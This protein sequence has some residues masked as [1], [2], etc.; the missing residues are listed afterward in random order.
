MAKQHLR[1]HFHHKGLKVR[2]INVRRPNEI[3]PGD[4]EIAFGG[5]G[6]IISPSGG[7]Q[8]RHDRCHDELIHRRV[9]TKADNFILRIAYSIGIAATDKLL[10]ERNTGFGI[11]MGEVVRL[12]E[13]PVVVVIDGRPFSDRRI[14]VIHDSGIR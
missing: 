2:T 13:I 4:V 11:P 14:Q 9:Q 8:I 6:V 3:T 5:F 10:V 7:I 12:D 1:R